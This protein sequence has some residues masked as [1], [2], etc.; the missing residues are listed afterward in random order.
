MDYDIYIT[1][2]LSY[3][4]EDKKA[5]IISQIDSLTKQRKDKHRVALNTEPVIILQDID[6][7]MGMGAG[8]LH[9]QYSRRS[10]ESD[11]FVSE[12]TKYAGEGEIIFYGPYGDR[13]G[14]WFDKDGAAYE[15]VFPDPVRTEIK[16]E[17]KGG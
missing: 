17:P 2:N 6:D 8:H 13:W 1:H 16:F 15:L 3:K 14:F 4:S 7:M 9:L 5:E 11:H 10:A 12:L